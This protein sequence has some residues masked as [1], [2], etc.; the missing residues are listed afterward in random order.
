MMQYYSHHRRQTKY[1]A[2]MAI[3]LNKKDRIKPGPRMVRKSA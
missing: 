1:D 2:V 3:E